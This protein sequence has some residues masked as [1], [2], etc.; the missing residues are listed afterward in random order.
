M[1]KTKHGAKLW[2][3]WPDTHFPE[4]DDEAVACAMKALTILKPHKTILLGDILDCGVFSAHTKRNI[5]DSLAYDFQEMELIPCNKLVDAI[6]KNTIEHTY[7]LEGNHEARVETWA[8]NN[9]RTAASIHTMLSPQKNIS[10]GRKNFTW[11]P[12]SVPTGDRM[13]YVE[14]AKDLVA[15]HGWSHAKHAAAKHL[16]LSR[17][18]SIL[19]G[20]T[21]RAQMMCGRDPWTGHEIKAFSPGCLSK[22]APL[23][24]HGGTPTDW[25]HGIAIIY[26][27]QNSWTEYII[28]IRKGYCVLPDGREVKI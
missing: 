3:I 10:K 20:H 12:Y 24:M 6:Q 11:V 22:L 8:V 25:V 7:M 13:G 4:Q 23:Y 14:I 26:V 9:G 27:G 16:D 2:L 28:N 19:H 18:R 15:V 1:A 5:P 17:S 21:H